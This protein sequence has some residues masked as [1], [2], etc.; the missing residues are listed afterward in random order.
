MSWEPNDTPEDHDHNPLSSPI[1]ERN[2]LYRHRTKKDR[3]LMTPEDLE[4]E[5]KYK[6]SDWFKNPW[7]GGS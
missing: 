1:R 3:A 5:K 2:N 7:N 4:E 6:N